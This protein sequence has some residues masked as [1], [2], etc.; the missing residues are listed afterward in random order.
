MKDKLRSI[1]PAIAWIIRQHHQLVSRTSQH[2]TMACEINFERSILPF[3]SSYLQGSQ[4]TKDDK[5]FLL[6]QLLKKKR[7]NVVFVSYD[8]LTLSSM[9]D[10]S[11]LRISFWMR[12]DK[13]LAACLPK[14]TSYR[15]ALCLWPCLIGL[16]KLPGL[17]IRK[18]DFHT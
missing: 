5:V 17:L 14:P 10:L 7:I 12:A 2:P 18:R 3:I 15:L 16:M 4:R 6:R 13:I 11:R 9:R 1:L 8:L